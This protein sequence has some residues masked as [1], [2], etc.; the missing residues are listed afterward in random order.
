MQEKLAVY[1][2]KSL[3]ELI[4]SLHASYVKDAPVLN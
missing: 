1:L 3:C 4:V 2:I